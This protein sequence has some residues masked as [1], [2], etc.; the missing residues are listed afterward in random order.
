MYRAPVSSVDCELTKIGID[1][2]DVT[3]R[4]RIGVCGDAKECDRNYGE[5][6]VNENR[7]QKNRYTKNNRLPL[8]CRSGWH[9]YTGSLR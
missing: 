9:S 8:C 1:T 5:A 2:D 3:V 6:F 4:Y 7:S